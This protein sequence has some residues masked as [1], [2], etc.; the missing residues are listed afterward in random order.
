[1]STASR[2]GLRR[3]RWGCS[4]AASSSGWRASGRAS[5][6]PPWPSR[7][8][9]GCSSRPCSCFVARS[10]FAAAGLRRCSRPWS[11]SSPSSCR[12]PTLRRERLEA[13]EMKLALVGVSHHR[14]AVELRERVA[15][16]LDAAAELARIVAGT[17]EAVVLSTCNRTEIYVAADEDEELEARAASALLDLAGERRDEIAPVL[18]RLADESAALHLFR[19]AAGLDSLVPREGGIPGPGTSALR[20]RA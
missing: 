3:F 13:V 11:R 6:M 4:P 7:S 5:S 10:G 16:E 8:F 1:P 15:I 20:A 19:V 17:D 2:P 14:A 18:Y 9:S 12:S